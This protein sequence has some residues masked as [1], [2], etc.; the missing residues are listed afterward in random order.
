[1]IVKEMNEGTKIPYETDGTKI[2]FDDDL[3][4][5]LAKRQEDWDVHIDVCTDEDGALVIGAASGNYYVAQ[6]DIPAKEYETVDSQE[7]EQ[8]DNA[9]ADEQ[10]TGS[11]D[12]DDN[13]AMADSSPE[14][15]QTAKPLDMDKVT[16]TLWALENYVE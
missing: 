16:M 10:A 9:E 2:C 4:I 6:I 13:E 11:T 3:T 5:N 12:T 1:M 14:P 8:V 15:I 7:D